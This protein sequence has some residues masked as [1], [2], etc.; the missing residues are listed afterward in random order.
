MITTL[1]AIINCEYFGLE[2]SFQSTCFGHVFPKACQYDTKEEKVYKDLKYVSIKFVQAN[3]QNA[4]LGL[5]SLE[6]EGRDG[7]RLMLRL[8]FTPKN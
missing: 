6:K 4:S 1:K 8:A 7:T 5:R 3:P 2:E